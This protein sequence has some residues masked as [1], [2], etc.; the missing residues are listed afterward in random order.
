M[1][2]AAADEDAVGARLGVEPPREGERGLDE[3]E[4]AVGVPDADR[5]RGHGAGRGV[6]EGDDEPLVVDGVGE[7]GFSVEVGE[8]GGGAE[9]AGGGE[10]A[11]EGEVEGVAVP[12]VGGEV[13]G[14]EGEEVDVEGAERGE[15]GGGGEV[16]GEVGVYG[17]EHGVVGGAGASH[18]EE[19]GG[20]G[21]GRCV[22]GEARRREG[23][24]EDEEDDDGFYRGVS[25]RRAMRD[26]TRVGNLCSSA[27]D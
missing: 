14:E 26:Q 27:A 18:G 20:G 5:E 8:R 7:V 1:E 6:E 21:G 15:R 25:R 22:H 23:D 11:G 4:L 16:A 3:E 10:G 24:E 17:V 19:R 12:H 2:L 13:R 9:G